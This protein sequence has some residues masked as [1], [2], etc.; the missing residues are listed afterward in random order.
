MDAMVLF[1]PTRVKSLVAKLTK[2]NSYVEAID[3]LADYTGKDAD[4][5]ISKLQDN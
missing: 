5:F 2:S 4:D 1:G 3:K